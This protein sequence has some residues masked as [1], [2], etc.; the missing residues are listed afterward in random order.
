M[1]NLHEKVS[2]CVILGA[3]V[4]KLNFQDGVR[5]YLLFHGLAKNNPGFLRGT[6]RLNFL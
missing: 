1:V 2:L 3:F 5:S 6:W 4:P